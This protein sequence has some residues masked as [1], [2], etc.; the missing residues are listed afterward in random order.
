M[1]SAAHSRLRHVGATASVSERARSVRPASQPAGRCFRPKIL[2]F[3][4]HTRL[5]PNVHQP[6]WMKFLPPFKSDPA[7]ADQA[8]S[9]SPEF[10]FLRRQ[11]ASGLLNRSLD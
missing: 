7:A 10:G 2:Q 3:A 5:A 1:H 6:P 9:R 4:G 11:D 8:V